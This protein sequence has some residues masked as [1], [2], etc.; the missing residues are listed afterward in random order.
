MLVHTIGRK[1]LL[2]L[3]CPIAQSSSQVVAVELLICC[4]AVC[5]PYLARV[6]NELRSQDSIL[7][8][9][10]S[11]QSARTD[12]SSSL[13]FYNVGSDVG[14]ISFYDSCLSVSLHRCFLGTLML[15]TLGVS[16]ANLRVRE[17]TLLSG[18]SN[19]QLPIIRRS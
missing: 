4:H 16:I 15:C 2:T 12:T 6:D 13:L 19:T 5:Y 14:A 11:R 3:S 1:C 18:V 8:R 7:H 10:S 9:M 17:P